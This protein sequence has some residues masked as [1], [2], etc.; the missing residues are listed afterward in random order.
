MNTAVDAVATGINECLKRL[1][2]GK[3]MPSI[4]IIN[5]ASN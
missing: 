2:P 5:R 1:M 4:K 3:A